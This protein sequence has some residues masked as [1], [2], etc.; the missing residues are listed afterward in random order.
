MNPLHKRILQISYVRKLSHL[1]S[2][3]TAVDII[4]EI[5]SRKKEDEPFILSCGHAFLA[6]AVVLEKHHGL[7]A[8]HLSQEYGTHPHRNLK[9]KIWF[10]SGSLGCGLPAALGFALA[11]RKQNVYCL[12]SDGEAAEG[13]IWEA[14]AAKTKYSV[15]NL[16]VYCN[17]NGY[18]CLGTVDQDALAK[19]LI[20]FAPDI[21]IRRTHVDERLPFLHG[22][23]GHYHVLRP[24]N[25]EHILSL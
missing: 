7:N 8:I 2:S 9:D 20:A 23:V 6:L 25:W 11:N 22:V 17:V 1:S 19:R 12:I 10:S 13:S 3:L 16:Q 4:D 14:L 24:E 5:Y 21:Q 18:S 15:D